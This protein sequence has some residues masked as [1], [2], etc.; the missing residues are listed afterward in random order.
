MTI[1][2][3]IGWIAALLIALVLQTGVAQA[4][5]MGSIF[6]TGHDPDFHA[7][8]GPNTVGAQ[9]INAAAIDFIMNPTFNAFVAGG[10][11][12][13]LFVECDTCPVP[14]GHVD[15]RLGINASLS[16]FPAGTTYETHGAADG[17]AT[18][19]TQLGTTYSGIVIGSDFGGMLTQADLNVLNTNSTTIINF[20]N[21]G[22]GLYAMAETAPPDGLASSGFFGFLPFIVTSD[23]LNE[24]ESGNT[25]TSFGA[26]LG[27]TNPDVNGNFSHNVFVSTGGLNVVDVDTGHEILSLAG[28]GT[29]TNGGVGVPEPSSILL[30]SMG[31]IGL[32][33]AYRRA[34]FPRHS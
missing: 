34:R 22:G 14:S 7:F 18:A 26:S 21:N 11:Q 13:F 15:G 10:N 3:T 28:R 30:L 6:L 24:T 19:L 32:L 2:Q 33:L 5:F 16:D 12:H 25:V 9:H 8:E 17:L 4:S 27:L 29:V 1:R 31:L 20:L 23:S